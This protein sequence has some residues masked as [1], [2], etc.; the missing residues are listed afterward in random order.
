MN[1][2]ATVMRRDF[3]Q[4]SPATPIRDAAAQLVASGL[5]GAPVLDDSGALIGMLTQKDCFAPALKASYYRQWSGTVADQMSGAPQTLPIDTDL[6]TA[7]QAF[8]DHPHRLFPVTDGDRLVGLLR[9][10]DLLAALLE[11]G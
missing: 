7:A 3:L 4:L 10:S 6:A 1:T 9:R 5:S 8:L 11:L 2:I